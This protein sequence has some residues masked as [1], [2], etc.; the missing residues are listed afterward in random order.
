MMVTFRS[1]STT[2]SRGSGPSAQPPMTCAETIVVA[3]GRKSNEAIAR[4][5]RHREVA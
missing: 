5:A 3:R 4:R 1:R 2:A